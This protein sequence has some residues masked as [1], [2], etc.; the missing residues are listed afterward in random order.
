VSG[1]DTPLLIKGKVLSRSAIYCYTLL[2]RII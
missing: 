1:T 2:F